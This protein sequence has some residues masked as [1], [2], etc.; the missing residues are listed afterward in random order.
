MHRNELTL[1]MTP[2]QSKI[3]TSILGRRFLEGSES[4]ATSA[5]NVVD[6]INLCK[7]EEFGGMRPALIVPL[8]A[9]G[10]KATTPRAEAS[11]SAARALMYMIRPLEFKVRV[12]FTWL[13]RVVSLLCFVAL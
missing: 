3:K 10:E 2:S 1:Q 9:A 8:P 7:C 4:L 5:P 6:V 13:F 11:V 12:S